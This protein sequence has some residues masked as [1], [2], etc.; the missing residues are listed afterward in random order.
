MNWKLV[1]PYMA[2]FVLLAGGAGAFVGARSWTEEP[3]TTTAQ[4]ATVHTPATMGPVNCGPNTLLCASVP[5]EPGPLVM[6]CGDCKALPPNPGAM[7]RRAALLL[8]APAGNMGAAAAG[9]E[10]KPE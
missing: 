6:W 3:T 7:E 2:L 1:I 5:T 8:L 4:P 9:G 10:A